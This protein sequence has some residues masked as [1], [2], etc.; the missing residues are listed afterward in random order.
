MTNKAPILRRLVCWALLGVALAST[1]AAAADALRLAPV[2][3]RLA[4]QNGEWGSVESAEFSPD[5]RYVVTGSK[6][7]WQIVMWRTSDG[8]EVWRRGVDDEIEHVAFSP[9]GTL[10][11]AVSEDFMLRVLRAD[12]GEL[13]HQFKHDQGID[14][15]AWSHDGRWLATGEER[16]RNAQGERVGKVRVFAMPAFKLAHQV[17]HGDTVNGLD[18]S[19]DDR[20]L[21]SAGHGEARTWST[22]GFTLVR[23]FKLAEQP[24]PVSRP[25]LV[26]GRFSPDGTMIAAGGFGGDVYVWETDT[27]RV[28]RRFNRSSVKIETV[29]WS[30]DGRYLLHAGRNRYIWVFRTADIL[31]PDIG[32]DTLPI[33]HKADANDNCEHLQF[34]AEGR[35]L[36]SAHQD[37]M[38]RLWVFMSEDRSV[39]R[40]ANQA[41]QAR[42]RALAEERGSKQ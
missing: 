35:K 24:D 25:G 1:P 10:V 31:N 8:G 26:S 14:A 15:V 23:R 32:H 40:L 2:W 21:L 3:A 29:E 34:D 7:D 12:D 4:D 33:V 36:V 9:D 6:F 20:L 42:Q 18:F 5:G 19:A 17:D 27:G 38:V 11:A 28:L 41:L 30:P 22:D 16:T 37:G 13:V 39:N